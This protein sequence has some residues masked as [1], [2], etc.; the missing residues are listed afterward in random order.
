MQ[1]QSNVFEVK[2]FISKQSYALL[3][4]PTSITPST[5]QL[6]EIELRWFDWSDSVEDSWPDHM[7]TLAQVSFGFEG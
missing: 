6:G 4:R 2:L 5:G 7:T 3:T 1:L